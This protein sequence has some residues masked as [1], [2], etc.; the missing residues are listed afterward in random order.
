MAAGTRWCRG[1]GGAKKKQS[2]KV[3]E[4]SLT[5]SVMNIFWLYFS[6]IGL[7]FIISCSENLVAANMTAYFW[8]DAPFP[9]PIDSEK[10]KELQ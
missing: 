6:L 8:L 9:K 7:K 2:Y 5:V 1:G 10:R 3:A 4:F